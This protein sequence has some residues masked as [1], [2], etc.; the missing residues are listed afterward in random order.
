MAA[1]TALRL[2]T[3]GAHESIRLDYFAGTFALHTDE[4]EDELTAYWYAL[5]EQVLPTGEMPDVRK[6]RHYDKTLFH[7]SGISLELSAKDSN[8]STAGQ[9]LLTIPGAAWGS[10]D[11]TER[12][13]LIIDI[14]SWPGFLRCT[15][16][17]CQITVLNPLITIEELIEEVAKGR[18]WPLRYQS[19]NTY[20][21]R[22][23]DGLLIGPPTQYFG[24][25]QSECRV[26]IYDHAAMHGWD[27]PS[28]RVENQIRKELADQ[29]FQRLYTRCRGEREQEP[30]FVSQE[31]LTVKDVLSQHADFRDTS[32]WE[33]RPK[34]RKWAQMAERPAWWAEMLSHTAEPLQRSYKP[35]L[36]WDA[37]ANAMVDQYGRKAY[38][39][40]MHKALTHDLEPGAVLTARLLQMAGKL[41][42]GDDELLAAAVPPEKAE[43]ARR[44]VREMTAKAAVLEEHLPLD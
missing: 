28:L 31:E 25:A 2:V 33:G 1:S 7:P 6:S 5:G 40:T 43:E 29:H 3:L 34:P 18:L 24:S 35:E 26:R 20:E 14:G 19:Q 10:L 30:L 41:K 32:R 42:K 21:Q 17:D 44:L 8:K 38:L 12:R 9:A 27:T 16:L 37:S 36:A 13:D 22:D 15:R 4:H 11:A 23:K 39:D